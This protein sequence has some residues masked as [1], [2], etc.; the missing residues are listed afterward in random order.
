MTEFEVLYVVKYIPPTLFTK[1]ISYP[2]AIDRYE[3]LVP[4]PHFK[5]ILS[6]KLE[7]PRH[8]RRIT[9][10]SLSLSR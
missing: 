3:A 2:S 4:N 5:S 1:F 7:F 10:R 9:G 6:Y 8:R